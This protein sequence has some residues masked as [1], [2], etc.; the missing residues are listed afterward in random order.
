[1]ISWLYR[2]PITRQIL[3]VA[4]ALTVVAFAAISFAVY[5]QSADILRENQFNAQLEQVRALAKT[6][7]GR[8][9]A[10]L[11]QADVELKSF[12]YNQLNGIHRVD[13]ELM[14]NDKPLRGQEQVAETFKQRYGS[15]VTVFS[16][17]GQQFTRVLTSLKRQDGQQANG[18]VLQDQA[19]VNKLQNDQ[20]FS[21][22]VSL[23]GRRYLGYYVPLNDAEGSLIGSVFVGLPLQHVIDDVISSLK[24]VRWGKTGYSIIVDASA[25]HKGLYLYNQHTNLIGTSILKLKMANGEANPFGQLF[26]DK[27][28]LITFPWGDQQNQIHQKFLAYA[29]VPGWNWVLLGGT[30]VSE[31]TQATQQLLIHTLILALGAGVLIIAGLWLLLGRLLKPLTKLNQQVKAFGQGHISQ[32][33]DNIQENSNNEIHQLASNVANMRHSLQSLV[34]QLKH[35]SGRLRH[36]SKSVGEQASAS[37]AQL[38]DVDQ[39]SNQLAT[40]IEEMAASAGSVAEQSEAISGEVNAA[41]HD[42]SKSRE[43]VEQMVQSVLQLEQNL[44]RSSQAIHQ[45][46]EQSRS[47]ERVTAMID[48]IAEKTNLLALNAAIEAARAGEQGRGFAVVA[49]EVRNLAQSTQ[50]SVKEVV[51]IISSLQ[52][53]TQEAVQIMDG[54]REMG[55]SVGQSAEQTGVAL[56]DIDQQVKTIA[57]MS[58]SIAATAEQ[59]AQVS[60]ELAAGVTQVRDDCADSLAL[61]KQSVEYAQDL[62]SESGELNQQVEFFH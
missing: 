55:L 59:Q 20:P 46:A 57:Q 49:D 4:T 16:Y 12:V 26:T 41:Q 28:G 18:T 13:G 29:H 37:R 32:P 7:S 33:I 25:E 3:Y 36:I 39:Q 43:Q 22:V 50:L 14:M 6:L 10:T 24:Q 9:Q 23:F 19:A 40:A 54:C 56:K 48:G 35:S 44:Q 52:Q 47:I 38:Q 21:R 11:Q 42:S 62:A 2:Q 58:D 53:S 15:D 17:N 5:W 31:L 34:A 30:F 8:Y 60:H 61:A 1:M 51:G 27:S 45:V